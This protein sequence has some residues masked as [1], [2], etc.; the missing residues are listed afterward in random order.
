M[1]DCSLEALLISAKDSHSFYHHMCGSS[2]HS[3]RAVCTAYTVRATSAPPTKATKD[4]AV[5]PTY[6]V[7]LH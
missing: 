7:Y 2:S 5:Q 4:K 1:L 6:A 3:L